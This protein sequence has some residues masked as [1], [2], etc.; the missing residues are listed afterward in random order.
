MKDTQSAPDT[1]DTS[2]TIIVTPAKSEAPIQLWSNNF[3]NNWFFLWVFPILAKSQKIANVTDYKFKLRFGETSKINVDAL[4]EAWDAGLE[5]GSPSIY[6]ALKTVFGLE[7]WAIAG[8]KLTWTFFTWA[9]I[10]FCLL[11]CMVSTHEDD[12]CFREKL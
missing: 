2:A 3:L 1:K 9:G 11:R 6:Q 12:Y 10:F 4:E 5:I 7:Y 8:Y